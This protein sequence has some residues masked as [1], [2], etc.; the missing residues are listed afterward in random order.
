[1]IGLA[2]RKKGGVAEAVRALAEPFAEG[3]GLTVW[4]VRFVREGGQWFLRI[5]IDKPGGVGLDDCERLSRALDAPL[6]EA[7]P[8]PQSYC[9]EVSSPGVNRE[10]TREEHFRAFA[11]SRVCVRLIRPGE[12]G[13]RQV[14]GSLLDFAGGVVTIGSDSG[15]KLAIPLKSAASVRL[16]EDDFVGGNEE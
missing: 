8:V 13:N 2:E 3:L 15:E 6:D 10:L 5:F 9:L 4:D 1:M 7:D 12:D 16:A 14:F 11:G